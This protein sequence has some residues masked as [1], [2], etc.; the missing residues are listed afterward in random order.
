LRQTQPGRVSVFFVRAALGFKE[1]HD[2]T[3]FDLERV[4]FK[5]SIGFIE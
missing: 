5:M 1:I 3:S 2:S 4:P